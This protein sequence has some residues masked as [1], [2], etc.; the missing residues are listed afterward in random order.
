MQIGD[1]GMACTYKRAKQDADQDVDQ[2]SDEGSDEGTG[3]KYDDKMTNRVITLWYRHGFAP[4]TPLHV[5]CL[6][7]GLGA[8]HGSLDPSQK[9]RAYISRLPRTPR[10]MFTKCSD[11]P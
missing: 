4:C 11:A 10:V 5:T 7:R 9:R 8:S 3:R 1:F 6:V 2:S